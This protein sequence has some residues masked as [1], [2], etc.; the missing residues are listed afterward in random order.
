MNSSARAFRPSPFLF[1]IAVTAGLLQGLQGECAQATGFSDKRATSLQFIETCKN[2]YQAYQDSRSSFAKVMTVSGDTAP[3][4]KKMDALGQQVSQFYDDTEAFDALVPGLKQNLSNA[5]NSP[6]GDSNLAIIRGSTQHLST[7]GNQVAQE[8]LTLRNNMANTLRGIETI[9]G[10]SSSA[11]AN[12]QL[13]EC[14]SQ[15]DKAS[16]AVQDAEIA[17]KIDIGK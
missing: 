2:A 12:A 1:C 9:N 7:G 3:F 5:S 11:S 13:K 17:V 15:R 4:K 10:T 6:N 16:S 14:L 8:S